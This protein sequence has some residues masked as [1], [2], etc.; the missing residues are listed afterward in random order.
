DQFEIQIPEEL[1]LNTQKEL[2]TK[3]MEKEEAKILKIQDYYDNLFLKSANNTF[4]GVEI[5]EPFIY[6]K[7]LGYKID[8]IVIEMFKEL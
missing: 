1:Y 3:V 6:P 8:S 5:D 7:R 2:A 4:R